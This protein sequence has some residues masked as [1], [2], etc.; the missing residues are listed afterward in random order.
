MLARL[1]SI[2]GSPLK[3][4]KIYRLLSYALYVETLVCRRLYKFAF[5]VRLSPY[6]CPL[7]EAS[8]N[9]FPLNYFSKLI[10]QKS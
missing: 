1:Q 9:L 10:E 4:L 5:S 6:H 8:C 2:Q 3:L 7:Q